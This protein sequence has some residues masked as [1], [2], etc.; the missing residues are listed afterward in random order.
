MV[1]GACAD[2][3][4]PPR[5]RRTARGRSPG[6]VPA[7]TRVGPERPGARWVIDQGGWLVERVE[8]GGGGA[9]SGRAVG[10]GGAGGGAAGG[11]RVGGGVAT[12]GGAMVGAV[13]VATRRD[14]GTAG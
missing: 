12:S 4:D 9:A 7:W 3:G 1:A 11:G 2:T 13:A 8:H 6:A 5:G 10:G 14:R